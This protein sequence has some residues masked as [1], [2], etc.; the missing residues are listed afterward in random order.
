MTQVGEAEPDIFNPALPATA[1]WPEESEY[2]CEAEG[3][4]VEFRKLDQTE[5]S[6]VAE[7][8]RRERINVLYEQ[9]GTQ[10]VA[11]HGNWSASAWDPEGHGGYSVEAKV[12]ELQ[13][14]VDNGGVALGALAGGR[15]VGIGVVV[16]HL[17]PRIAQLAFLHVSAPWRATGIGGRLSEQ[18]EQIA[19][20]AGD[21]DMVVS[22]TPSENTVRFYLGRG[23]QP[24]ADPLAELF[25]LEPEDVHMRKKL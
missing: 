14:Y 8:D 7:I 3:S 22:A 21:S 11:R 13:H 20:T 24:M 6:R 1:R 16:P 9:H 17:R 15:L 10:L 23:F 2:H 25:E 18:L 12:H 5:L 4:I 19:R